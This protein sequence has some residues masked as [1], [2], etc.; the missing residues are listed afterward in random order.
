MGARPTT[1]RPC[2]TRTGPALAVLLVLLWASATSATNGARP[3]VGEEAPDFTLTSSD[4]ETLTLS[5]M[6][7]EKKVLLVFFRGTW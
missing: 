7:G 6:R 1:A 4:G 5:A 3:A 2:L